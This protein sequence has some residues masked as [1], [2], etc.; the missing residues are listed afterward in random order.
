MVGVGSRFTKWK[1]Q[2]KSGGVVEVNSSNT[3]VVVSGSNGHLSKKKS[4]SFLYSVQQKC[5]TGNNTVFVC[6]ISSK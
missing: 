3:S 1:S 4:K 2:L 5:F 6:A